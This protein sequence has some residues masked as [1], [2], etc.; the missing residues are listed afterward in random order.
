MLVPILFVS[1]WIGC[2]DSTD[3]HA[4]GSGGPHLTRASCQFVSSGSGGSGPTGTVSVRAEKVVTGLEV[5]WAMSF[6]PGGDWLV[7]ERPG[8]LR[9]VRGGALVAAPVMTVNVA[10][11]TQE[12]GLLGLALDP[13]FSL[14][15]RFYVY[16]TVS[17]NGATVNRVDRYVLASNHE[18]ATFDR[19]IVDG[20]PA[21]AVHDGGRIHF[22]PDGNLYI[23]TGDS[24]NSGL[25][26]NPA[27]LAG[28]I[29]A[30][31]PDGVPAPGN[32]IPNNPV[33]IS[34]V[35]N[36]EAFDF[37]SPQIL[38]VAEHGPTGEINGWTG[39][40]RVEFVTAG[41]NMGWPTTYGCGRPDFST[42]ALSW[43]EASPP[44]GAAIY[45]GDKIPDWRGSLFIGML[46]TTHLHRVSFQL[47][48]NSGVT[49]HE[50]Y[51]QGSY[52]RLRDVETGSDGY[53]YVTT[54]N[55]DGRGSCP[56]DGDAILKISPQ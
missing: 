26:Q 34:G 22:G 46:G 41:D 53:L 55:C 9:L 1:T 51:F 6:L 25:A 43:E 13:A 12:G 23:S 47:S 21:A 31:T 2:N 35:R 38:A 10:A 5:P 37:I 30:V 50:V 27:S 56:A 28:K 14:N 3:P 8:R 4:N 19:T 45:T 7:T 11:S 44:G 39:H 29:L 49:S 33:F 42:A 52:G 36:V 32:P 16:N 24:L 54:S 18:S 20:I 15:S 40:D 48:P 17:A